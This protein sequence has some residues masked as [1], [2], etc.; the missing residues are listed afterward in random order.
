MN[1][2]VSIIVVNWNGMNYIKECIDS[3]LNLSYSDYEIILVD[4]A[5]SDGSVEFVEKN[6]PKVR[7]I[8]NKE[9]LGFAEGNNIGIRETKGELIALFNPDAVADKEWLSRLVS[10]LQNSENIGG[11]VG[12]IYYYGDKFGKDAVFCTWSKM[13]PYSATPYNFHKNEP[14]SK[15][16]YLSGAAMVVKRDMI[17]KIGFLDP[18]YFLY[19]DETDWCARMIRGG[20]DLVYVP[21]AI[22]WH[23]VSA[24]VDNLLRK[25]YYMERGRMRF[26][27]KNFDTSYVPIFVLIF[28]AESFFIFCR[29]IKNKNLARTKVRI[30]AIFWNISNLSSTLKRRNND[31]SILKKNCQVRSY[32]KSLPLRELKVSSH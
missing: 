15:V 10:V 25:T 1:P 27:L 4:N 5:S 21:T 32:N 9:N 26:A 18:D 24:S 28:L 16:D 20:Y 23:V 7:I 19:F 14:V 31:T 22:A 13:D 3:L 30:R 29:D 12:K 8:R 17:N 2:H 11:V 6:Y